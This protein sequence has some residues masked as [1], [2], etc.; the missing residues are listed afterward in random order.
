MVLPVGMAYL[1][2]NVLNKEQVLHS[3]FAEPCII[4]LFDPDI[5]HPGKLLGK[6][7][8]EILTNLQDVAAFMG[9]YIDR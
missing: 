3:L 1:E 8:L 5:K 2:Y 7:A 4:K 9:N 6:Y